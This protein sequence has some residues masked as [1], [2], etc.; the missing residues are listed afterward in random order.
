MSVFEGD[1]VLNFIIRITGRTMFFGSRISYT[2]TIMYWGILI[3]E[4]GVSTCIHFCQITSSPSG[5]DVISQRKDQ[6]LYIL[7]LDANWSRNGSSSLLVWFIFPLT[8]LII[9]LSGILELDDVSYECASEN[10]S[11]NNMESHIH[12]EK[13][14][15]EG[16]ILFSLEGNP[17]SKF[18]KIYILYSY[19][20]TSTFF[21]F[22]FMMC[23]PPFYSSLEEV[24]KSEWESL[25]ALC[26]KHLL[27]DS[28]NSDNIH[29]VGM[30]RCRYRDD[31]RQWWR[32]RIRG[33]NGW[34]KSIFSNSMQVCHHLF[35]LILSFSQITI[36][37]RW[38]TSMLGKMSSVVT[39]VE[40]FRKRSVCLLVSSTC[41]NTFWL[42]PFET[43]YKLRNNRV[44]SRLDTS[45]GSRLVIHWYA[46]PWCKLF[47]QVFSDL[48]NN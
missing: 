30:Y 39:I 29:L 13:A 38:Y 8:K 42:V 45:L 12:L 24:A 19:H 15:R 27:T 5:T 20:N 25:C 31:I 18:V 7:Y 32:R 47:E 17:E 22:E 1:D 46:P 34:R 4:Y 9:Y 44:C 10:V 26:G 3:D 21:S 35:F 48:V 40:N 16:S 36:L 23:N 41:M 37:T 14:T 6:L 43:D 2:H 28:A 33:S 11:T